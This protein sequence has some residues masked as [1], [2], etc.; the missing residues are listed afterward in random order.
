MT[1]N[2]HILSLFAIYLLTA[3]SAF[4]QCCGEIKGEVSNSR[5][6]EPLAGA[7]VVVL[8]TNLGAST[9]LDGHF[10]IKNV[11]VGTYIVRISYVGYAPRDITDVVVTSAKPAALTV[12]LEP[13]DISG[14]EVTV[15]TGYFWKEME[16]PPSTVSLSREEIRR[17][18]GGF[19]DVVRTVATL[20]GVSVVN[21]GGRND[22]LV[23][24]GGPTENL[25]LINGMEVPNIN[26]FGTQGSSSGS[27]SY[28]N[29]DFIEG[30]DF[31]AGGFGV[32]YGDKLSSAMSLTMRSPMRD[33]PGGKAT[34]SASQFGLNGE[35]PL[36]GKGGLL[37]SARKSYLDLI[38][39]AAGLPF[40]PV[41]VDYNLIGSYEITPRDR[42]FILG[43]AAIDWV[44]RDLSDAENRSFNAGIM[45]NTQNQYV[46]GAAYRHI[47]KNGY[48]D[49]I[50]NFNRN[51]YSFSQID[52][53]QIEYFQSDAI[54]NET[55]FKIQNK[56][57]LDKK[58]DLYWGASVKH[59]WIDNTTAFADS[60]YDSNGIKMSVSDLGVPQYV[61]VNSAAN[62][63]ALFVKL[64][65][66][67]DFRTKAAVGVRGDYYDFIDDKFYPSVRASIDYKLTREIVLKTAVGRYYQSPAYVW[68]AN[69]FNQSLKALK[70]DMGVIGTDYMLRE[71]ISTGLEVYYKA[72]SDLPTGATPQ[73]DYLVLSNSGVGYGGRDDNFQSFGYLPLVSGGKGKAY[74]VEISVQKKYADDKFYGQ[75]SISIGKS[76]YT[77][78]NG[79]TYPGIYDQRVILTVSGGCKPTP[80]WEFSGKFRFWTGAPYTPVYRPSENNGLIENI[81]SEYLSARLDP[82]HHLDLRADRRFDFRNW[83]AIVFI[84][85]Q[86]IYNYYIPII[87]SY[88][89]WTD[90]VETQNSIAILPSIGLSA[91]F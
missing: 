69:P 75:A 18:P 21:A 71:D 38:F 85:I 67:L 52:E 11:P 68:T 82:G 62:K 64:E 79:E 2:K 65:R 37:F 50:F 55:V 88:N 35:Y 58:S 39:K 90:E 12:T 78:G 44:D 30:V 27:L 83:S 87:P 28:V 73:T 72:Y 15:T 76:D 23:R 49:F 32:E 13:I 10:T 60:V 3:F 19:E 29:L 45:D 53:D 91:E 41:Y 43:L 63:Y 7:N 48:L 81:P 5:T 70:S 46:T 47:R 34:I 56:L 6:K 1:S 61:H 40:V 4:A 16:A 86:N 26:H 31:S 80:Q 57:V 51:V 33:K 25:Y 9:D 66:N 42:L 24:G 17:F 84:D 77:A 89:F 36:N 8:N 59:G 20:P 14:E 22:L 74:G 54:E